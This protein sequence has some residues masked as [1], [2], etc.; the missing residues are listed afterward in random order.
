VLPDASEASWYGLRAWIEP[1]F[2]VIQTGRL[3]VAAHPHNRPLAGS[4]LV[5]SRDGGDA[6][7][8]ER[9]QGRDDTIPA[10]T[11]LDLSGA[12]AGQ[13]RQRQATCLRLVSIVRRRWITI[14][15]AWLTSAPLPPRLILPE[16]WSTPSA[17]TCDGFIPALGVRHDA[18]CCRLKTYPRKGGHRGTRT[19]RTES[20][21]APSTGSS[22]TVA[23]CL[24]A[25]QWGA[26]TTMSA[27]GHGRPS[28]ASPSSGGS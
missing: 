27:R 4:A 5:A 17:L 6:G 7:A 13:R 26:P 22:P 18:A 2:K 1:G 14:P 21:P 28:S 3:A 15:V 16:P 10:G 25:L 11:W 19:P 24:S 20:Q 23:A 9:R 12:L 8:V